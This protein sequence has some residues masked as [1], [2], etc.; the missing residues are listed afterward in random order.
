MSLNPFQSIA[1]CFSGGGYRASTFGLGNLAFLDHLGLRKQVK[2]ISTVS[3][4][5]IT[6]AA[7]A[8]AQ[9]D[10]QEFPAFFRSFYDW[11]ANDQ[12]AANAIS[13]LNND[14]LWQDST[15]R[16]KRQT[17]INAF[18][19]EYQKAFP[20]SL[21]EIEDAIEAGKCHVDRFVFN[22]TDF[23]HGLTF[24]I[25]NQADKNK[26][27]NFYTPFL[28]TTQ[29]HAVKLGD[30]IAASSCFPGGFE[31]IGFP[32]DFLP[33]ELRP[34][35]LP[36]MG[37]MD[38]GIL[39]NQG[40]ESL[41]ASGK[42]MYDSY[43]ICD[44]ESP[45]VGSPFAFSGVTPFARLVTW[46]IQIWS[47]LLLVAVTATA[48][49]LN[50]PW[51]AVFLG[52]I[53]LLLFALRIGIWSISK[54][55]Q[56]M[57]GLPQ[58]LTMPI[59]KVGNYILD[60]MNSLLSMANDVTLK[61]NRRNSYFLLYNFYEKELKGRRI[62]STI[63][64]LR[65]RNAENQPENE[66]YWDKIKPIIGEIPDNLKKIAAESAA[67]P[68]V[69]WFTPADRENKMLDKLITTGM[70]TACYNILALIIGE[71]SEEQRQ[72]PAVQE[73]YTKTLAAWQR[74][75]TDPYWLINELKG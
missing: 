59:H 26:F 5:T 46:L 13:N 51:L 29:R 70:F 63:Y 47:L 32:N 16:H 56:A 57:L 61:G 23:S 36:E 71:C 9:I 45:Y 54:K 15:Y 14:R 39:D 50:L 17:P 74:F 20:G 65:C 43:F 38:G 19:I 73:I 49:W 21:G 67:F 75:A 40:I 55:A 12:L 2:A 66:R 18:A 22:A 42:R 4:G 10:G 53:S 7:Y 28:S 25:Q 30:A 27:G 58:P 41:F 31:P 60:R 64:E 68:T 72:D 3:G 48:F 37:I 6:G 35:D 52:A 33:V 34:D 8:Q 69:L 11:L 24:R 1:L 62:A 44:V